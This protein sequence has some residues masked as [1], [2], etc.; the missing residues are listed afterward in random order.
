MLKEIR[1]RKKD[2]KVVKIYNKELRKDWQYLSAQRMLYNTFYTRI[3][4]LIT[5]NKTYINIEEGFYYDGYTD[6]NNYYYQRISLKECEKRKN[7]LSKEYKL[8]DSPKVVIYYFEDYVIEYFDTYEECL[9]FVDKLELNEFIK[10][11]V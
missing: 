3:E 7:I 10:I 8:Y 4:E 2:I 6:K 11:E 5:G 9:E 1:V